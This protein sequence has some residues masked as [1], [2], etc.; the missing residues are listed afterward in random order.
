MAEILEQMVDADVLVFATPIYFYTMNGQMKTFI[1]R[2]VPKYEE[3]RNKDVYFIVAAADSNPANMQKAIEAFRG[4][5]QDCLE[6]TKEKG[7]IYGVGAW[8]IGDIKSSPAMKQAYEAGK[9]A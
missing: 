2:T 7:I 8:Q 6:G 4:F 9:N 3:I 1:D 5:T